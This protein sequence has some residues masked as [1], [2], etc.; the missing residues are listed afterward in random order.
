MGKLGLMRG[1]LRRRASAVNAAS[2]RTLV[3]SSSTAVAVKLEV[4]PEGGAPLGLPATL[5]IALEDAGG[6][7][8]A[9]TAMLQ[10][11]SDPLVPG[12]PPML[13][14]KKQVGFRV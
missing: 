11:A 3:R 12:L 9:D 4:K 6:D 10:P 2:P 14:T 5:P 7:N 8:S 13:I 1:E